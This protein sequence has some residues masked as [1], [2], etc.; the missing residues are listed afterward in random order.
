M[1]DGAYLSVVFIFGHVSALVL[2]CPISFLWRITWAYADT[3]SIL[4]IVIIL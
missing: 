3:I 1:T 4:Y 2:F